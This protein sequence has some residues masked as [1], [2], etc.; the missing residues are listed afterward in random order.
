M[1]VECGALSPRSTSKRFAAR[2]EEGHCGAED[3]KDDSAGN[4]N[5][6]WDCAYVRVSD[7]NRRTGFK[8]KRAIGY[9]AA[10]RGDYKADD[11]AGH[12]HEMFGLR[13]LITDPL[14]KIR[15]LLFQ[16]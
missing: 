10:N 11:D 13:F 6:V 15:K 16:I 2:G 5:C 7:D 1:D 14:A 9:H 12:A 4:A 8:I 3:D